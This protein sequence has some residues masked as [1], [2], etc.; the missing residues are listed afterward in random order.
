MNKKGVIV[1]IIGAV[2]VLGGLALFLY[3]FLFAEDPEDVWR[4]VFPFGDRSVAVD[5]EDPLPTPDDP[6]PKDDRGLVL[7]KLSEHPV[8]EGGAYAFNRNGETIVRYISRGEGNLYEVSV[9]GEDHFLLLGNDKGVFSGAFKV[10]WSDEDNVIIYSLEDSGVDSRGAVVTFSEDEDGFMWSGGQL[11][12]STQ[13]FAIAP[14]ESRF[15]YA[16]KE[17]TGMDGFV[18][19]FGNIGSVSGQH[20]FSS[21]IREW[22]A[23]W[24]SR[25]TVTLTTR[26]SGHVEGHM[27]V[28]DPQN[29]ALS[30]V[31]RGVEGL[32]TKTNSDASLVLYNQSLRNN[33]SLNLFALQERAHEEIKEITTLV[34]KCV[35]EKETSVVCAVPNTM[36]SGVY[37]DVWYQGRVSFNDANFKRLDTETKKVETF[38]TPKEVRVGFENFDAYGL[39]FDEAGDHFFFI[40]KKTGNLWVY[41]ITETKTTV[42]PPKEED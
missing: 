25:N 27:Y 38:L 9:T 7:R 17:G 4:S 37:P 16:I 31:L 41:E 40:D 8:A 20:V 6:A 19:T 24:P 10:S 15:F 2:L 11:P 29:R 34:D 42:P 36:P 23:E 12:D 35:W 33:L 30:H 39:F 1:I 5:R 13:T 28:L 26:P 14:D 18:S 3:L 22:V 32:T 21:P